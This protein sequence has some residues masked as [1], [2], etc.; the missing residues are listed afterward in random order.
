M[1]VHSARKRNPWC[2]AST[3]H[4]TLYFATPIFYHLDRAQ[5][6]AGLRSPADEPCDL[7]ARRQNR[8]EMVKEPRNTVF[9][10]ATMPA[11]LRTCRA[12]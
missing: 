11:P 12:V 2:S 3:F 4:P 6:G 8:I 7:L 5:T 10:E 1:L 9:G